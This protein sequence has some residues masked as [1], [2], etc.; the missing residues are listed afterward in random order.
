MI[1]QATTLGIDVGSVAVAVAE[2]SLE[3][4]VLHTAYRLHHG[5]VAETFS[6]L[7]GEFDTGRVSWT[8][9]TSSTPPLF[10]PDRRYDNRLAIIEAARHL[11]TRIGSILVVGG[12]EFG[13]IGFDRDGRYRSFKTNTGCAAGTGSFLDQQARRLHLGSSAELGELACRNQGFVPKIASR[14]AVFAKT[15]LVHAQQE[16]YSLEQICDGLCRGL[17]R[18]IVDTLAMERDLA[19]PVIFTGGV[20]RNRAVVRHLESITGTE[21]L[22][23]PTTVYGAIGAA[24]LLATEIERDGLGAGKPLSG[25]LVRRPARRRYVHPPLKLERSRHPDFGGAEQHEFTPN[26]SG[27]EDAVEV[28]HYETLDGAG[29]PDVC[30]GLDIGSTSTKAVLLGPGRKVLAGLYTGTAGRPVAAV[31]R[32]LASIEDLAGSEAVGL[33]ITGCAITG[34]GR[35]FGGRIVGADLVLDEITAHACAARH[36]DPEVDTIFE[37]GGQD[38]KFTTLQNGRVTFSAMNTV[39]AAGTG[40]FIEEQARKLDCTLGEYAA[41]SENQP[42]PMVSDRCTVF[43]ERDMNQCLSDGYAVEEVLASVLHAI[44]GNYLTKV[45][46]E[47]MIGSHVC[48]QGATARNRSLVAAFEQRLQQPIHVSRFCHL[49]G[50][51]GAALAL[52]D[53]HTVRPGNTRFRGLDLHR[54]EIA[55]TAEVC[56]LCTNHCKITVADIDGE[57]AAYGFL[58]GRD[59]ETEHFVDGNRSG[60]DL[61]RERKKAFSFEPVARLA[62][63]ITIGIPAAVHLFEDLPFWQYFFDQLGIR[64]ITSAEYGD[65]YGEGRRLAGAEFCAPLTALHGHVDHLLDQ[66]DYVFLPVYLEQRTGNMGRRR[67]YC[68]Y[69]QFA[70]S[71]AFGASGPGHVE[72]IIS[73]LVHYLYHP[74]RAR[75]DLHAALKPVTGNGVGLLDVAR[76]YESAATFKR[77][78][79]EKIRELFQREAG[80]PGRLN[81]VLLGRPY[82]VLSKW[83]NKGIPD[84]FASLGVKV[85]FQD[86]LSPTAEEL[87]PIDEALGEMHWHY[88]A[89]ILEAAQAVARTAGLYP[90]L[91][92]SFRCSPDSFVVDEVKKILQA[93]DKPYLVLQLD[94]HESS[95]GYTTRIE[96][97]IRSFEG[98][99]RSGRSP[100]KA[101]ALASP[102]AHARRNGLEGK[103]LV[104]PNW[105]DISLSLIVAG[106]RREGIDARLLEETET[107]IQKSL[108]RNSGQCIP[109]DIIAQDFIDYVETHELDPA[110]TVLWVADSK[111]ACNI[112]LYPRRLRDLIRGHG[113]GLELAEVHAG[114]M[115]FIDISLKLPVNTYLAYLF[116]GH[117]RKIGC[118]L[119]PYE[120]V[121]G[122]TDLA[123]ERGID[124]LV[125]AFIGKRRKDEALAEVIAGL[126]AVSI[127]HCRK[128]K[129]AIF[130]DFYVR[131]NRVLNQDLI[132]FIEAH[133]GEVLVTPYSSYVRMVAD[134]YLRKWFTEG[135]YLNVLSTRALI[136]TVSR[137]EKTYLGY[138]RRIVDEPEP[139]YGDDP[140]TILAGYNVRGEHT[141]ES[142][143][144]LLKIHYT[145]KQHPDVSLF[146]QAS[147]AFCCAS[148]IT[149]AMAREIERK[150]GVPVVSITYDG[151]TGNRNEAIIPYLALR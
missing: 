76:A 93:C 149:E 114:P 8:G 97:A 77:S 111:I 146:V 139:A 65:A 105:D 145:M 28:T 82:T 34:A 73:P 72:R 122:A 136:A 109:V 120:T 67:H 102:P 15:D 58:C 41:R 29:A 24:F 59:Y 7:L 121:E 2:T 78:C 25:L 106:L 51:L 132:R 75:F 43:M 99:L 57:K 71:L 96:A 4:E 74:L 100:R 134:S 123:L 143:D 83:M 85:F 32:I 150:T 54:K 88:A 20:S 137:L 40:S 31:Q 104:I 62:D 124:I 9:A 90:V 66:A 21:L 107:T 110:H 140:A 127:E 6:D 10:V 46:V 84:I 144:N 64:T 103:T 70:T 18:N 5:R 27:P 138:F 49:T 108:R 23:D 69:T 148:L 39:C 37:I 151:T 60:F 36:L 63:R 19:A 33:R 45:A 13:L 91:V 131:D 101:P 128:R 16:G 126:E 61:L 1:G 89:E 53:G 133:G 35:S 50:A 118:R 38:S 119:R 87:G 125:D 52:L 115:S 112:G 79:L 30:L 55:V 142:M 44:T 86:M 116:G 81:V 80:D 113:N 22:V 56:D 12:E 42:S 98:H 117:L 47:G 135:R 3:R 48:F 94:E 129:V 95:I 26:G 147:P 17:A 68:Y 14:C 11:H 92:T 141:G 130:G